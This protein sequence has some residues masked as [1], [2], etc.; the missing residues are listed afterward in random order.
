M[1]V[2]GFMSSPVVTMTTDTRAIDALELMQAKKIRRLPITEGGRLTGILTLGD[3][4]AVLGLQEHSI[5]RA[6]TLLG[7]LMTRKVRTVAPDDP[8]ERAARVMLDHVVSGLPVLDGEAVVGIITESDI[9]V[10]FTRIMGIVE[11]GVRVVLTVPEGADLM[12]HLARRT[13]GMAVRSLAAYPSREGGWEAVIRVRGRST[14]R[15]QGKVR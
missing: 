4:Q 5:R 15:L 2:R 12:E 6:S 8:L 9:F 11:R 7:D 1:Y 10:A 3:L 13:A 14:S